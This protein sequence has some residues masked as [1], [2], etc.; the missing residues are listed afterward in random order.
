MPVIRR[1]FVGGRRRPH[2]TIF[3]DDEVVP[4][5][6]YPTVP[7]IERRGSIMLSDI[8]SAIYR[9]FLKAA[10]LGMAATQGVHR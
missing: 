8:L 5:Q 4:Q 10:L 2:E 1:Q 6:T 3:H 9:H 7:F